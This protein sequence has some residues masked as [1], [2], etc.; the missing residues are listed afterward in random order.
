M[1]TPGQIADGS[2]VY[3]SQETA[4]GDCRQLDESV[5]TKDVYMEPEVSVLS[6]QCTC[7]QRASWSMGQSQHQRYNRVYEEAAEVA[8]FQ[9]RYHFSPNFSLSQPEDDTNPDNN[10]TEHVYKE[11]ERASFPPQDLNDIHVRRRRSTTAETYFS[12]C[13]QEGREC[14]YEEPQPAVLHGEDSQ[15]T[16]DDNVPTGIGRGKCPKRGRGFIYEEPQQ[17]VLEGVE[18]LQ[19]EES[20]AAQDKNSKARKNGREAEESVSCVKRCHVTTCGVARTTVAITTLIITVAII[21]LSVQS[22]H[23]EEQ[24]TTHFLTQTTATEMST[25]MSVTM[26]DSNK[27]VKN[28]TPLVEMDTVFTTSTTHTFLPTVEDSLGLETVTGSNCTHQQQSAK[29]VKETPQPVKDRFTFRLRRAETNEFYSPGAIV[30]SPS[31]NIFVADKR[32]RLIQVYSMSGDL[33]LQFPTLVPGNR[34]AMKIVHDI[35]MDN[36]GYLWVL[37]QTDAHMYWIVQYTSDGCPVLGFSTA[38]RDLKFRGIADDKER[39]LII[40]T[41]QLNGRAVV[42]VLRPLDGAVLRTFQTEL[43]GCFES[44]AVDQEGTVFALNK[45]SRY[46]Y[47]FNT[48][49]SK[50]FLFKFEGKRP[51]SIYALT[52]IC[53]TSS[54]DVIVA[55]GGRQGVEMYTRHGEFVRVV[56]TGVQ[57]LLPSTV[58]AGPDGQLLI[59]NR[60]LDSTHQSVTSSLIALLP[61]DPEIYSVRFADGEICRQF[62]QQ[63][64]TSTI[65]TARVDPSYGLISP[66]TQPS[67]TVQPSPLA[68]L[69]SSVAGK[70]KMKKYVALFGS[71][72]FLVA[73][74]SM[75]LML[76][77]LNLHGSLRGRVAMEMGQAV[78]YTIEIVL[79]RLLPRLLE[80]EI[81][82]KPP[83]KSFELTGSYDELLSEADFVLQSDEEGTQSS[84]D[85][86]Y[87]SCY[88]SKTWLL[89]GRDD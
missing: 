60:L 18:S 46:V 77:Q 73:F 16:Q 69:F 23:H 19:R 9:V 30:V 21:I 62:H 4:K 3:T 17:V 81:E 10:I 56:D 31:N 85:I 88:P 52:G 66:S 14:A 80:Q 6:G 34:N 28:V 63:Y 13:P 68:F 45:R 7:L 11:P 5:S 35:S 82:K 57:G 24:G 84:W 8:S 54:G 49:S 83:K 51:G 2:P 61:R 26:E 59:G 41:G 39:S 40:I 48:T 22:W 58:A 44:V 74:F 32:H 67:P 89:T 50:G 47:V 37:G 86:P 87:Q 65:V 72:M 76:D 55:N 43:S 33:L 78:D 38:K 64:H 79:K 20:Q 25:N 1:A 71:C 27:S 42:V 75:Y 36:E 53:L 29:G 70:K 15:T 12:D